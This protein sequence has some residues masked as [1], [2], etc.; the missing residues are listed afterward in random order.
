MILEGHAYGNEVK[1]VGTRYVLIGL[2]PYPFPHMMTVEQYLAEN[3][4]HRGGLVPS[5]PEDVGGFEAEVFEIPETGGVILLSWRDPE[6]GVVFDV[7]STFDK[8]EALRIVRS[9]N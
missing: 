7:T 5:A 1:G 6:R 9:F 8:G 3:E 4:I 2:E